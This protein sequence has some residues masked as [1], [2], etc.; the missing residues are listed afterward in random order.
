MTCSKC[1]PP[2]VIVRQRE[3]GAPVAHPNDTLTRVDGN[4]R[5][6]TCWDFAATPLKGRWKIYV[7]V[8][9][10]EAAT[11]TDDLVKQL[12][13]ATLDGYGYVVALLDEAADRIEALTAEI[14]ALKKSGRALLN[15]KHKEAAEAKLWFEKG[16]ALTAENERLRLFI[17][18]TAECCEDAHIVAQARTAL[19]KQP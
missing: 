12:R 19:E 10:R 1:L 17:A 14:E 4:T 18:Y 8:Y 3:G 15:A 13:E 11:L 16:Q 9:Q 7:D 5:I 2:E 6:V